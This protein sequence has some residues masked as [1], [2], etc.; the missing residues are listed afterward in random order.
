MTGSNDIAEN[1]LNFSVNTN[2]PSQRCMKSNNIFI[3]CSKQREA[4]YTLN[5]LPVYTGGHWWPVAM[6]NGYIIPNI[7]PFNCDN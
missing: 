7:C 4:S 5:E 3:A 6:E 1:L 2:N